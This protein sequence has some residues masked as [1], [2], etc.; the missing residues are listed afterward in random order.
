MPRGLPGHFDPFLGTTVRHCS[1]SPRAF[2][3]SAL[4]CKGVPAVCPPVA[5]ANTLP[6][7][8][9][10]MRHASYRGPCRVR[11]WPSVLAL[12]WHCGPRAADSRLLPPAGSAAAATGIPCS[13]GLAGSGGP[14]ASTAAHPLRGVRA[15]DTYVHD[16]SAYAVTASCSG[17][18]AGGLQIISL[19]GLGGYCAGGFLSDD[20]VACCAA[21]CGFCGSEGCAERPGGSQACCQDDIVNVNATCSGPNDEACLLP[22]PER[23]L[24]GSVRKIHQHILLY[25]KQCG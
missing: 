17:A 18:S 7:K 24:L 19:A 25:L 23:R 15:V 20:G 5:R 21:S 4:L 2:H 16:G 12:W 9:D 3:A 22:V 1:P 11:L 14:C 8:Q 6:A 10:L 13:A